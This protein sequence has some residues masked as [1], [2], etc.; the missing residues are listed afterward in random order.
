MS[1][2]AKF[3]I[4]GKKSIFF[5][6]VYKLQEILKLKLVIHWSKYISWMKLK[7][8]KKCRNKYK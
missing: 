4:L 7:K 1:V 2:H 3:Q 5:G 8:E 6:S